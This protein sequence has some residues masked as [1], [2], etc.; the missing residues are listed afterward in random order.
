MKKILP[1]LLLA[2][3]LLAV[4]VIAPDVTI[5]ASVA[6]YITVTP[7]YNTVDFGTVNSGTTDNTPTVDQTAGL[8]NFIV[9]TN[10]NYKVSASGSDFSGPASLSINNLSMDTN[11]TASNLSPSSSVAITT[12]GVLIDDNIPYTYG[13]NYHGYWLTIPSGQAAGSYSTTVT[14]TVENVA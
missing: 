11:T 9:D 3:G 5:T 8:L 4:P 14:I 1:I 12:T 7:N 2:L 13:T 6:P 10:K